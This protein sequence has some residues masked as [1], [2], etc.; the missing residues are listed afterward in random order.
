MELLHVELAED[1][2]DSGVGAVLVEELLADLEA[3]YRGPDPDAPAPTDFHPPSGVFLVAWLDG[4]AVGC[5]GVRAHSDGTG[6]LKRMYT[7]PAA[8]RRGIGGA[9]LFEL[10][11]RARVLGH[12]R[13]VLETG[14]KQPEAI[15]M[16]ESLGY[17]VIPSYGQYKDFPDSR[18]FAKDL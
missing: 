4:E 8:R 17:E 5:G 18:C 11:A 1:Q 15:A 16:Y 7:R 13:L 3:R 14:T 2:I 10:E 9:L 6:E 12:Q